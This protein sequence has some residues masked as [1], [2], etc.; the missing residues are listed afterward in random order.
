L[1]YYIVKPIIR[2]ALLFFCR[3]IYFNTKKYFNQSG[4]LLLAVNH[5]NSFLDAILIGCHFKQPVY[6]LA[7]GDA[8]KNKWALKILTSLKCI[9]VY[10]LREG[11]EFLHLNE[12]SFTRCK[13]IFK[14][15]GIVLIFTEGL[16]ENEWNIRP[17]KKGT[18]RL[19][20][21]SW[22]M[23]GIGEKLKVL[24]VGINY[25]SF[26]Q[27]PKKV[28][29]NFGAY[30][31][32]NQFNNTETEGTNFLI[33]NENIEQQWHQLCINGVRN[34]KINTAAIQNYLTN[35][36]TANFKTILAK[37]KTGTF[38]DFKT[39]LPIFLSNK[40]NYWVITILLTF[41]SIPAIILVY[42]IYVMVKRIV[43]NKVKKSVHYDSI[44]FGLLTLAS[45]LLLICYFGITLYIWQNI[46]L[47]LVIIC[48]LAISC[49]I[50]TKCYVLWNKICHH[51]MA[52]SEQK[53]A[54]QCFN[55]N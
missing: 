39:F 20:F 47:S 34:D 9:P 3:N 31:T 32:K 53:E 42:P 55:N 16:C 41:L 43:L 30:I 18:A 37:V 4:P 13:E 1:L 7:R 48:H 36:T 35:N 28:W 40:K 19:A 54:L 26:R 17:L 38:L 5:P 6:F 46:F 11:K 14:Q 21:S 44:L 33:L 8:F 50:L 24:P 49:F 27:L 12:D 15:N 22:Q 25:N 23:E 10:R 51:R 2:F 45:L 29:I 52:Q